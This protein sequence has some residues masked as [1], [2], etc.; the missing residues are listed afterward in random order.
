MDGSKLFSLRNGFILLIAL[1][2]VSKLFPIYHLPLPAEEGL[3]AFPTYIDIDRLLIVS[4]L[5][6]AAIFVRRGSSDCWLIALNF[7]VLIL[8]AIVLEWYQPGLGV[9][10]FLLMVSTALVE[11]ILLRYA[12]FELFWHRFKPGMIV[13]VSSIFFTLV[14]SQVYGHLDYAFAVLMTGLLLGSIYA[15]FR[16]KEQ[17]VIGIAVVSWL[18]LGLILMGFY[19]EI[20]PI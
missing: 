7:V 15:Y 12:L 2:L 9:A 1:L 14:H 3:F 5:I 11:E 4:L 20:I 13:V 10:I 6:A 19:L 17:I 8:V 18:H 16:Y